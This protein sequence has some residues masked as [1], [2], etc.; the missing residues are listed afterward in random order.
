[1]PVFCHPFKE[2]LRTKVMKDGY[3]RGWTSVLQFLWNGTMLQ[4]DVTYCSN[5]TQ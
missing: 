3:I 1:M 5:V 4:T 2:M